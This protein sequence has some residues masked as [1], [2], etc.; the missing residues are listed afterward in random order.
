MKICGTGE[1][2]RALVQYQRHTTHALTNKKAAG[3]MRA[4]FF[5]GK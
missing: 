5:S 4:A 1:S 2:Q 3:R